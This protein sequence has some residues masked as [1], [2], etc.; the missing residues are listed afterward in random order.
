MLVGRQTVWT[1]RDTQTGDTLQTLPPVN[2]LFG[3]SPDYKGAVFRNQ[4]LETAYLGID[5]STDSSLVPKLTSLSDIKWLPNGT[6]MY[7]VLGKDK[8]LSFSIQLSGKDPAFLSIVPNVD[9]YAGRALATKP[10]AALPPLAC[11]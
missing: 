10:G 1:I 3:W 2:L 5:G 6:T 7:T 4:K 9:A 8:K 11:K